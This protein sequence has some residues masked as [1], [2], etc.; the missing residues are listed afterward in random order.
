VYSGRARGGDSD[1]SRIQFLEE[2]LG[3]FVRELVDPFV[4]RAAQ[5]DGTAFDSITP[6]I[7]FAFFLLLPC[8]W[9]EMMSRDLIHLTVA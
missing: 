8:A 4:A 6:R 9:H 1:L 7:F 3:F 2:L 5:S